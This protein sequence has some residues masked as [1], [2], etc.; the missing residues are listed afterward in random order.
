MVAAKFVRSKHLDAFIEVV[1]S[2][3]DTETENVYIVSLAD[4][5]HPFLPPV[6]NMTL[7]AHRRNGSYFTT[8]QLRARIALEQTRLWEVAAILP[9]VDK[10]CTYETCDEWPDCKGMPSYKRTV[11]T[12]ISPTYSFVSVEWD[13]EYHCICPPGYA[14]RNC[15]RYINHCRRY[16]PC[17]RFGR[18]KTM[19]EG[20]YCDC[21]EGF[22]GMLFCSKVAVLTQEE[23]EILLIKFEKSSAPF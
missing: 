11:P 14:G 2:V 10:L 15:N 12:V 13:R 20:T 5:I 7:A 22:I 23:C 17:Q 8:G 16:D 6:M 4:E 9:P 21:Q 1:A 18:C 3:L 19:E